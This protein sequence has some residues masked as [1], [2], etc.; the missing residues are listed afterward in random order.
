MA[1]VLAPAWRGRTDPANLDNLRA[2]ST[3]GEDFP[4]LLW[5]RHG[6]E[7]RV[8]L[9]GL[10]RAVGVEDGARA[11]GCL[12]TLHGGLGF[13]GALRLDR[14]GRLLGSHF[15]HRGTRGCLPL[16]VAYLTE[17]ERILATLDG[18]AG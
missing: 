14:L 5:E 13:F 9:M 16:L 18:L 15:R 6:P 4:R 2:L 3:E 17:A 12:H 7:V 10:V 1:S 8:L 11:R